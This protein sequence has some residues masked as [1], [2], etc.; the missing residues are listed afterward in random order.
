MEQVFMFG[1][2]VLI[3][4]FTWI[5]WRINNSVYYNSKVTLEL[6]QARRDLWSAVRKLEA[7]LK[8]EREILD[9]VIN[10]E[11]VLLN[12][13]IEKINAGVKW[14]PRS[15]DWPRSKIKAPVSVEPPASVL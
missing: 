4:L 13:L 11:I 2:L 3:A 15:L 12:H 6:S 9:R 10:E 5:V 7:E 8:D 14:Q 1:I